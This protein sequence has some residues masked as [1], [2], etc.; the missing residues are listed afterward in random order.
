MRAQ[1][2]G[3]VL[4]VG[5]GSMFRIGDHVSGL[6]GMTEYAVISDRKLKKLPYV[7]TLISLDL[8]SNNS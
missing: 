3:V 2:L 8:F 5:E 1:C 4:E 7:T 6:W